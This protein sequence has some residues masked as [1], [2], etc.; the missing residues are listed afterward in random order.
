MTIMIYFIHAMH[1][2]N[3]IMNAMASQ[4]TSLT[5]VYS[6]VYSRRRSKK[7]S[8]LRVTGICAGNSPVTGEFPAQ[9]ASNAGNVSIWWR[10]HGVPSN[11]MIQIIS[12]GCSAVL[13]RSIFAKILAVYTPSLAREGKARYGVF[14]V[15]YYELKLWFMFFYSH[16]S[17]VCNIILYWMVL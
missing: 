11:Q 13:A 5:I 15:S 12:I 3:V 14:T 9:R 6:T 10:H 1:Y 8:K 17:A 4:I 7:I 16:C 2:K